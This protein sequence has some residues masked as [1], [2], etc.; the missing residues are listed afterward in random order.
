MTNIELNDLETQIEALMKS[1]QLLRAENHSL[2]QKLVKTTQER[3]DL[4]DKNQKATVKIKRIIG[5]LR[6]EIHD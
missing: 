5:Q 6:N 1:H 4:L 2:R 3:A